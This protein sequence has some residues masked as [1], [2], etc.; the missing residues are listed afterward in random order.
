MTIIPLDEYDG[1]GWFAHKARPQGVNVNTVV[2]HASAGGS[3]SGAVSTLR[4]KG[5]GY[6]YLIDKSG[7]VYKGA[8]ATASVAHAGESVGPQGSSCNRYSIGV[9]LI[10]LNDGKDPITLE[11]QLA[12]RELI[13]LLKANMGEY[14]YLTTHY[15]ITVKPDGSARKTDPRGV[16]V[17]HLANDVGLTPWK[18]DYAEKFAL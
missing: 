8:P 18:P 9:C 5:Y 6:H 16:A 17:Q 2:L 14:K 1:K 4:A 11:Q 7:K 10:N 15:A 13:P 12:L 3:L